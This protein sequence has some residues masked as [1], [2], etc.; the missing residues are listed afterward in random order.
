MSTDDQQP[1]AG[2]SDKEG[3]NARI[4][5]NGSQPLT[6]NLPNIGMPGEWYSLLLTNIYRPPDH[7]LNRVPPLGHPG[8]YKVTFVMGKPGMR[9]HPEREIKFADF[10]EGDSHLAILRPAFAGAPEDA[11][12]MR[13][14]VMVHGE[15]FTFDGS[16]NERGYLAKLTTMPFNAVNRHD[17][18][19]RATRAIQGVLSHYSANLDIPLHFDL[20]ETTEIATL[21]KNLTIRA[22]FMGAGLTSD[23][24][25]HDPEFAGASALYREGLLS[26]SPNYRFLCFFKIIE[27]SRKRRDRIGR[28][29][30]KNAQPNRPGERVP[31]SRDEQLAWLAAVYPGP[32]EWNEQTLEQIFLPAAKGKKITALFDGPLREIR[33]NIA[34]GML[35]SGS[36]LDVDDIA[37][38]RQNAKWL[39]LL[40]CMVRRI[41]K[42]DFPN[43]YLWFLGEDGSV[44]F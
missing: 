31:V 20:V 9:S 30:K 44:S 10:L 34:H 11:M 17:A 33:H 43:Q 41:L 22:P 35:D 8:S 42:N 15:T 21:N 3:E 1:S 14:V 26:N 6:Y 7:P 28:K 36:F 38:V 39:P 4:D 37:S 40:R 2:S 25:R 18:E 12:M 27:L 5:I 19:L 24:P 16:A 13:L 32:R 23:L 29:L